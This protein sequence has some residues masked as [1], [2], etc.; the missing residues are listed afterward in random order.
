M[1]RAN[2]LD[3]ILDDLEKLARP[4]G[5]PAPDEPAPSVKSQPKAA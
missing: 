5:Q 3:L 2:S 1:D 4:A